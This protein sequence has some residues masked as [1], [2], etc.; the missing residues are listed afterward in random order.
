MGSKTKILIQIKPDFKASQVFFAIEK[1]YA[2]GGAKSLYHVH[3]MYLINCLICVLISFDKCVMNM[4]V[5]YFTIND[6]FNF[7]HD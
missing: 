5:F 1:N 6:K 4:L 2:S 7:Q 3:D